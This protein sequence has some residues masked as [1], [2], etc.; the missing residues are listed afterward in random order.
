VFVD[1]LRLTMTENGMMG[2]FR[3]NSDSSS[4]EQLVPVRVA[5]PV[6]AKACNLMIFRALLCQEA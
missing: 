2:V 5:D 4:I 3:P 1:G 6:N